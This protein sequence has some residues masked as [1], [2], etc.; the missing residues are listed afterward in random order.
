MVGKYISNQVL[1]EISKV[2]YIWSLI[3]LILFGILCVIWYGLSKRFR[4]V[5]YE[6]AYYLELCSSDIRMS[7][8][9][10]SNI[11]VNRNSG[12]LVQL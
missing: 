7:Q 6:H 12:Y 5:W 8:V 4:I 9:V 1:N 10:D 3:G 2:V 11:V